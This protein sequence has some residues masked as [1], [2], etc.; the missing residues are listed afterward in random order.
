MITR[1]EGRPSLASASTKRWRRNVRRRIVRSTVS[2]AAGVTW[3]A[4]LIQVLLDELYMS[5]YV[6]ELLGAP[7]G[8]LSERDYPRAVAIALI[9]RH[10][11]SADDLAWIL[12]RIGLK[13]G[14]TRAR[15]VP[16]RWSSPE[17][18]VNSG[19]IDRPASTGGPS[20]LEICGPDSD[21]VLLLKAGRRRPY[22][23]KDNHGDLAGGAELRW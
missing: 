12:R 7:I 17:Q 8:E 1:S 6:E 21:L 20:A 22:E 3:S 11:W 13:R 9:L 15:K 10:S 19:S 14:P 4:A 16:R 23:L 5:D 2:A 18:A